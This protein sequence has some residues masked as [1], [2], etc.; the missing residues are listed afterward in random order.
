MSDHY[1]GIIEIVEVI[2][3]KPR[4]YRGGQQEEE[5]QASKNQVEHIVVRDATL[6]G[7]TSKLKRRIDLINQ[8][9]EKKS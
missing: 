9:I 8:E 7:L 2:E 1:T 4:V 6:E 5:V 3:Y